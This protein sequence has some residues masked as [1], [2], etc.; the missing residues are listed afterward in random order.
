[1]NMEELPEF[2]F[3]DEKDVTKNEDQIAQ[4]N[5]DSPKKKY[6]LTLDDN[7]DDCNNCSL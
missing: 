4:N 5:D 7:D 1:M 2:V 6:R 3:D